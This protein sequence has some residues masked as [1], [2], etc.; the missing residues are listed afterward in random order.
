MVYL[1]IDAVLS[2][3]GLGGDASLV[4]LGGV[5]YLV[6]IAQRD[7]VYNLAHLPRLMGLPADQQAFMIGAGAGPWKHLNTNCEMM[8]NLKLGNGGTVINN[9]TRL[10][11]VDASGRVELHTVPKEQTGCALLSNLL[12]SRGQQSTPVLRIRCSTRTGKENFVSCMRL[13]LN[14]HYPAHQVV[15]IIPSPP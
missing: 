4:D 3:T 14:R 11:S 13:A 2:L 8:T 6:P 9:S 15:G 10:A 5:P 1:F 7:R 12:V